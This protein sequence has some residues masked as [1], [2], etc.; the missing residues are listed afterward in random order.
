MIAI[1]LIFWIIIFIVVYSFVGYPIILFLLSFFKKKQD[2]KFVDFSPS[3]TLLISAF[4]EEAVIKEKIENSL[5]L[6]YSNLEIAIV[7]D[8]SADKTVDICNEFSDRIKLFDFKENQGKN[9]ALNQALMEIDS[10]LIVF[11]D[12]NSIYN[13]DAIL[14]LVKHFQ[15]EKIGC[16]NGRLQLITDEDQIGNGENIYWNYE[17][18]L[19]S[20]ESRFGQLISANGAIFCARKSLLNTMYNDIPNDFFIP[21]D[22]LT[23]GCKVVYEPNAVAYEKTAANAENE[24]KR[25]VR[26]INRSFQLFLRYKNKMKGFL[27]FEFYSHKLIRWMIGVFALLLLVTSALLSSKTLYFVL[28]LCQVLLY[29][30]GLMSY[31][32]KPKSKIF[33]LPYYIS[34][35]ILSSF[36]AFW[37]VITGKTYSKWSNQR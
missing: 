14:Q 25:K 23:Q 7:S 12:A 34:L 9:A 27:K 31:L 4:N 6:E 33:T 37:D 10:D 8:G 35:I 22:I 29:T 13:K 1:E 11:S 18:I 17:N 15:D 32:L 16:V 28:L 2:V 26:I 24:Y 5:Q 30:T 36:K 20:L 21:I 19:K 3:V